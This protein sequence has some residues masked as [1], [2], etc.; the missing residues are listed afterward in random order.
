MMQCGKVKCCT[1]LCGKLKW[2]TQYKCID[3]E[4]LDASTKACCE[5]YSGILADLEVDVHEVFTFRGSRQRDVDTF[6]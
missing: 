6:L 3:A 5:V 4:P 1:I 2:W